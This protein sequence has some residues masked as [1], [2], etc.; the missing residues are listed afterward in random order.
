LCGK[1]TFFAEV[2]TF[3]RDNPPDYEKFYSYAIYSG[4]VRKAIHQLKYRRDLGMG[5]IM[6]ELIYSDLIRLFSPVDLVIPMPLSKERMKMR[7]Y[8]QAAAITGHFCELSNWQHAPKA[9]LKIKNT[10]SQVHLSVEERMANLEGAFEA[11]QDI[12]RG[13]K[14]LIVDDVFTTGSTMRQATKALKAGGASRVYAATIARA[15]LT[16][17]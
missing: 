6:A 10:E 12:V 11:D 1:P 3:C 7:G 16:Q 4:L 9:L 5:R 13:K 17:V 14:V 8:N 15:L 2:C